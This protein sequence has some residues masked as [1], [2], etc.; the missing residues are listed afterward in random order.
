MIP[1]IKQRSGSVL[2]MVLWALGLLTVFTIQIGL[3]MQGK[4]SFLRRMERNSILRDAAKSGI[5][6]AVAMIK[7]DRLENQAGNPLQKVAA[8]YHNPASFRGIELADAMV[9]VSYPT[10]SGEAFGVQD[11]L[12]KLNVNTVD[13]EVLKRLFATVIAL[14]EKEAGQL[15]GAIV[16]WRLYGE[17]EI[18]GFYS[19]DYYENLEFSYKQKKADFETLDELRLVKGISD[20]LF[21]VLADY[22]TV[23]GSGQIN[24]N[25]APWQ[26]LTA[27]GFTEKEAMVIESAR[28][29]MDGNLGTEDDQLY[30]NADAI[31]TLLTENFELQEEDTARIKD[32]FNR[33]NFAAQSNLYRIE[34]RAR[35]AQGRENKRITSVFDANNDKIIYW[36]EH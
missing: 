23:Y 29:G 19:D 7:T 4:I 30:A 32:I 5:I 24:V 3:T 16:D 33:Y 26:V 35:F 36:R 13:R 22:L 8:V 14:T 2:L 21:E 20:P 1:K 9:D 6:K 12:G 28:R 27:L 31:R 25:S 34:S 15:A 10:N 18:E 11:E 17:S